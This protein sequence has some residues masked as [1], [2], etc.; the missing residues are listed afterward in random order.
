MVDEVELGGEFFRLL[1]QVDERVARQVAA[2]GCPRCE[3][4]LHRGVDAHPQLVLR[5]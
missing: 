2:A 1:E 5:P 3:G 4:P